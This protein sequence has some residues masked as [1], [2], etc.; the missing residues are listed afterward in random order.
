ML[1]IVDKSG[2]VWQLKKLRELTHFEE[3]FSVVGT[4]D[5]DDRFSL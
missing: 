2:L 5:E 3:I 4:R 1:V